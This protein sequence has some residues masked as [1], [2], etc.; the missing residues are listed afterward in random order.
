[1]NNEFFLNRLISNP[2]Y[3]PHKCDFFSF[4]NNKEGKEIFKFLEG[5]LIILVVIVL[6]FNLNEDNIFLGSKEGTS[7]II[8]R[9]RNFII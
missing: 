4:N 5:I 8:K 6:F 9:E 3:L 2:R 1:M 7:I